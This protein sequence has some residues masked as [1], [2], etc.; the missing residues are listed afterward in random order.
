MSGRLFSQHT[1]R[2][3]FPPKRNPALNY[4]L[5]QTLL[6]VAVIE[7]LAAAFVAT[8]AN[9]PLDIR[10]HQDLQ[11]R[12]RHGSQEISIAALLQQL[13]KRHSVVGHRALGV[14]NPP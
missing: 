10:L 9:Q 1:A 2:I 13:D 8:G 4:L 5:I 7:P 11:H 6:N 12:L 14:A 3:S